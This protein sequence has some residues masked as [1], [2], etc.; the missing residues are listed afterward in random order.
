MNLL[1]IPG[2]YDVAFRDL[3]LIFGAVALGIL[4][5]EFGRSRKIG[6]PE[7]MESS[8]GV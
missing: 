5:W 1:L 3:G 4:A 6:P 7:K 2:F 8:P